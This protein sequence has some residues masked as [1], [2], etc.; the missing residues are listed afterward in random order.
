MAEDSEF[1]VVD[2]KDS[3]NPDLLEMFYNELMIPT[4]GAIE[5]QLEDLEVWS[6]ILEDQTSNHDQQCRLVLH[7]LLVFHKSDTSKIIAG[8]ACEYYKQV[9]T[10]FVQISM[11]S[12]R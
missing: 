11:K 8:A 10:H 7:V 1:Q 6:N 4:F 5:D 12:L 9:S 2:M 3:Y